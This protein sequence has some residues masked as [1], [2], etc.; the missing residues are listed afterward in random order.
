MV[1]FFYPFNSCRTCPLLCLLHMIFA[2]V[3]LM[4]LLLMVV[5]ISKTEFFFSEGLFKILWLPSILFFFKNFSN[6]MTTLE[7]SELKLLQI[8]LLSGGKRLWIFSS[9]QV[10]KISPSRHRARATVAKVTENCS[11]H[12]PCFCILLIGLI[13]NLK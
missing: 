4:I 1:F 6:G 3:G 13:N 9:K 10:C 12:F 7:N 2:L 11:G 8:N 5:T